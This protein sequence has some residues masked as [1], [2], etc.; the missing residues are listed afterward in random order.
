MSGK[1]D[2]EFTQPIGFEDE[3][4]VRHS[5]VLEPAL[6]RRTIYGDPL[7]RAVFQGRAVLTGTFDG[8]YYGPRITQSETDP[9]LIVHRDRRRL[10]F[11]EGEDDE[12]FIA[13]KDKLS[14]RYAKHVAAVRELHNEYGIHSPGYI[15]SFEGGTAVEDSDT[16]QLEVYVATNRVHGTYFAREHLED[17]D[18]PVWQLDQIPEEVT[19]SAMS[20]IFTYYEAVAD[21]KVSHYLDDIRL[22]NLIHGR[23][24]GDHE[25]HL[26]VF[27]MED[28]RFVDYEPGKSH[29]S[30]VDLFVNFSPT[31]WLIQQAYKNEFPELMEHYGR[32]YQK[33]IDGSSQH[34]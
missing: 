21:G 32:V 20:K 19:I 7:E 5:Q 29:S 8:L 22:P 31:L 27:D 24:Q 14:E 3:P 15:V 17:A 10:L 1:Y 11:M 30:L 9:E 2:Q 28:H 23:L 16:P 6:A 25:D 33:L 18:H 12:A 4:K 34:S 13:R 26:Y